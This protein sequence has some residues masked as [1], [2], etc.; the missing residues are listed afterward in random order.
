MSDLQRKED[1]YIADFQA[2]DKGLEINEPDWI[3]QMRHHALD[4]FTHLGFPTARRGN[5]KWKYTSV[6][7]IAQGA[8]TYPFEL[9]PGEALARDLLRTAPWDDSWVNLV[10][11]NG[12]YSGSLST[13]L[14]RGNGVRAGNLSEVTRGDGDLAQRHLAQQATV[15]DDAF[16]ALN[17]AFLKDGAFVHVPEGKLIQAPVHLLYLNIGGQEANV[18]H[19]RSLVV[20]GPNSRL[21]LIESYVS[22]SS[23]QSFTNAVT[24]VVA[25][26]GA[27]IEHYRLLLDSPEAFHVGTTRVHQGADSVF[28]STS[29]AKGAAIGRN[30]L[31]V[32]L[33]GPGS[34]CNLRGLYATTDTQHMDNS[35]NV[36]HA[37]PHTTS[38]LQ[39]RG[40]LDGKS[41][42]VFGGMVLVRAGAQKADSQQ[43]D[44]NLILSGEA[45]VDSKPSLLIYADDVKCSHGATTGNIDQETLFYMRSRGLDVDTAGDL[46]VR[47]FA[48]EILDTV[49]VGPFLDYLEQRFLK[50]LP[51]FRLGGES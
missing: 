18:S 1:R 17:T 43:S 3:R 24:E 22:L 34:S 30:D 25:G 19:P 20:A 11:V 12:H 7:S 23:S 15:E 4:R 5:E 51:R 33:D 27:E 6:V 16:T 26:D 14:D 8:F 49:R 37:K 13:P 48:G 31:M 29:F 38:R 32:L 35:I 41:R 45:E 2:L 9:E 44:K 50:S 42:A 47:G 28:S 39:Y 36:D 21:T 10:F 46:L 40:I